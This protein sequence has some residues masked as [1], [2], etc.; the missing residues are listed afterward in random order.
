MPDPEVP[1]LRELLMQNHTVFSLEPGE[2]GETDIVTM[3]IDTGDA[4]PC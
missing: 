4:H 3:S 1:Q 2:R